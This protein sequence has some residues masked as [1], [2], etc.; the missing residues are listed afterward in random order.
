MEDP[1]KGYER[2]MEAAKRQKI[3]WARARLLAVMYGDGDPVS[4]IEHLLD[5]FEKGEREKRGG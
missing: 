1:R 3:L 5:D 4:L 2:V